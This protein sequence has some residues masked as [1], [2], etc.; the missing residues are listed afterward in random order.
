MTLVLQAVEVRGTGPHELTR[1]RFNDAKPLIELGRLAEAARLLRECQQV[2]QDLGDFPGVA[3]VLGARASLERTS[4][5]PAVAAD[6]ARAALRLGYARPDPRDIAISHHNLANYLGEA[7]ADSAGQRAHRLAAAVIF[8]LTGMTHHLAVIQRG[9]AA[10]LRAEILN[11]AAPPPT[12][13]RARAKHHD[14]S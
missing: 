11:A 1:T 7:G 12:N 10:E 8:R 4:G 9:L 3:Q 2:Y 13:N 6:L 14:Q 5:R